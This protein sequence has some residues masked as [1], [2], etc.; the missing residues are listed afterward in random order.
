[1]EEQLNAAAEKLA[2]AVKEALCP[3]LSVR[4]KERL[5]EAAAAELRRRQRRAAW[6]RAV[7]PVAAAVAVLCTVTFVRLERAV[8]TG[9]AV[10][11]SAALDG[12]LLLAE[13]ASY[14]EVDIEERVEFFAD[15]YESLAV[16]LLALQGFL[17]DEEEII[18]LSSL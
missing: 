6:L 15:D 13:T 8:T 3:E 7:L 14:G 4:V 11:A 17:D 1:L 2:P 12:I 9:G 5:R 18:M 16:R 10:A